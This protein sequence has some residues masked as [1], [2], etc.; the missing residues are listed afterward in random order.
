MFYNLNI[1]FYQ[2]LTSI[3][4]IIIAL[5]AIIL[6]IWQLKISRRHNYNSL[7]PLLSFERH[8]MRTA[9]GF[10]IYINNNGNGPAIVIDHK[11]F[12]D[13]NEIT[14]VE[15]N[16]WQNAA[17]VLNMN[18]TFIQMG[19]YEKDTVIAPG[20]RKFLLSVDENIS[21]KQSEFF[22]GVIARVGMEIHYKSLYNQKYV[23][24]LEMKVT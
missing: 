12:V 24:K 11:I 8:F 3:A 2:L 23:T 4:A 1:E 18:Y 5:T 7:R 13:G 20:E 9:D 16:P 21:D 17:K 6:T 15:Q 14:I 10:G 22:K 19:Y